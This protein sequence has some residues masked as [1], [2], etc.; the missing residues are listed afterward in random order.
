MTTAVENIEAYVKAIGGVPEGDLVWY[1]VT[2]KL[3]ERIDA[4]EATANHGVVQMSRELYN[5]TIESLQAVWDMANNQMSFQDI[6]DLQDIVAEALE[7][8]GITPE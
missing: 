6:A 7:R 1:T 2:I 3:A 5:Q 8:L 4:L